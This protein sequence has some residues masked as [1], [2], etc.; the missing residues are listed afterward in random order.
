MWY[1]NPVLFGVVMVLIF[2][3]IFFFKLMY[4]QARK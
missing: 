4:D 3:S 1:E 2:L